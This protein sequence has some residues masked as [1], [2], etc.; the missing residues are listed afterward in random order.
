MRE[1]AE[2]RVDEDYASKLF[3]DSEGTKLGIARKITIAIDDPRFA[4]IGEL[5]RELKSARIDHSFMGGAS[6]GNTL[7]RNWQKLSY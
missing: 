2:L 7:M 3:A 5:Q 6:N 4:R 1:T